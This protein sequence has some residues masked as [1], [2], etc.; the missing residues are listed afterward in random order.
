MVTILMVIGVVT[1][2]CAIGPSAPSP[3]SSTI[4]PQ[5]T[6][7][8]VGQSCRQDECL[9]IGLEADE[10]PL[11]IAALKG[12]YQTREVNFAVGP[13]PTPDIESCDEFVVSEGPEELIQWFGDL[14][15]IGNTVNRFTEQN[16]LAIGLYLEDLAASEQEVIRSSTSEA[17]VEIV[18]L[19]PTPPA[20]G[21]LEKCMTWVEILDVR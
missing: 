11:G 8:Q 10:P 17:P 9:F 4:S 19:I 20:R 12:S 7:R 5:Y 15:K 16:Q 21:P 2:A 3:V 13:E 14:I 18:V 6:Y 1:A